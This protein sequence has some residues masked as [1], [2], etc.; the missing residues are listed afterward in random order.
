VLAAACAPGA[1]RPAAAQE[2]VQ[3]KR[4]PPPKAPSVTAGGVRYEAVHFGLRRGLDQNGGYISAIDQKTGRELWVLRVYA[5]RQDPNMEQDK[6]D[7]FISALKLADGG[8]TLLVTDERGTRYRVNLM[9]R[10]VSP[11]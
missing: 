1:V 6:Q 5:T 9:D 4:G 7:I 2:V 10:T 11:G 3:K 8:R